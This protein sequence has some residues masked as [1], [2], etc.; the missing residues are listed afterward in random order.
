M[1][2]SGVLGIGN[3]PK[4]LKKEKSQIKDYQTFFK[5]KILLDNSYARM[6]KK[7]KFLKDSNFFSTKKDKTADLYFT[8]NSYQHETIF[9]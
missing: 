8:I 3:H 5:I 2:F 9:F 1:T 7:L 6:T 4:T